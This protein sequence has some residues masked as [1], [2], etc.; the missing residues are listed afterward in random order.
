M[1][2]SLPKPDPSGIEKGEGKKKANPDE[3]NK[4]TRKSDIKQPSAEIASIQHLLKFLVTLKDSG[5]INS[6]MRM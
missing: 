2:L 5:A 6:C 3:V 1:S 4:V